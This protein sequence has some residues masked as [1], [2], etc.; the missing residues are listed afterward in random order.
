M[1]FSIKERIDYNISCDTERYINALVNMYVR[2]VF[3]IKIVF[4]HFKALG[5]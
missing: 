4:I 3:K 2:L 1:L 5:F